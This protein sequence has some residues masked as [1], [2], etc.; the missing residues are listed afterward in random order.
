[1]SL[2]ESST[3]SS[4]VRRSR[5]RS[6]S[7]PIPIPIPTTAWEP[8]PHSPHSPHSPHGAGPTY[9][10]SRHSVPRSIQYPDLSHLETVSLN[11]FGRDGE[12][13]TGSGV[14]VDQV[15]AA[16]NVN[17]TTS[18]A[19]SVP[20][21]VRRASRA[22]G[23]ATE[24]PAEPPATGRVNGFWR[25]FSFSS[26][27]QGGGRQQHENEEE[28]EQQQQQ[29]ELPSREHLQHLQRL[30]TLDP[31]HIIPDE[32]IPTEPA[33]P[34]VDQH[35]QHESDLQLSHEADLH[36]L[37]EGASD[38]A[39]SLLSTPLHSP[40][41]GS[42]DD[43]GDESDYGYTPS[44]DLAFRECC[45]LEIATKPRPYGFM[46]FFLDYEMTRLGLTLGLSLDDCYNRIPIL[47]DR[48][49]NKFYSAR[50]AGELWGM[51]EEF[52]KELCP[53]GKRVPL[54]PF[55]ETVWNYFR[56][57]LSWPTNL[58]LGGTIIISPDLETEP[59][60]NPSIHLIPLGLKT[61][62]T[63]FAATFGGDRFLVVKIPG[64]MGKMSE[65]VKK[66]LD[67][68]ELK[69]MG[70][71]WR[72]YWSKVRKDSSNKNRNSVRR[73][74]LH[75]YFFAESGVGLKKN[76]EEGDV[77]EASSVEEE[78]E[79]IKRP[80]IRREMT[81][82]ELIRWHMPIEKHLGDRYGKIWSRISLG[83]ERF[84]LI[85]FSVSFFNYPL[86]I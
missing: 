70:R 6:T 79:G 84:L 29:E 49:Y 73:Y 71:R 83:K 53:D 59:H 17:Y 33:S 85:L 39:L 35:L 25:N 66:R 37:E 26:I 30:L 22:G 56:T 58:E 48:W 38:D 62:T 46:T 41:P 54:T 80:L 21:R 64:V 43:E 50:T 13:R 82:D 52:S 81:R 4:T 44:L 14:Q 65:R 9:S 15:S 77:D 3:L 60:F 68:W 5:R 19:S 1:M 34:L 27:W 16:G 47:A 42:T 32:E 23:V 11:W 7:I 78:M 12:Y 45:Q 86:L 28:N 61:T 20:S 2:P 55:S 8:G 10:L 76:E 67:S 69:L 63:K 36:Q 31:R 75:A 57:S 18:T 40:H 72:Y 51:M 24:P 74:W